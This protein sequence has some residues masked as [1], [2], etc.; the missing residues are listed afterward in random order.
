MLRACVLDFKVKWDEYL[1]LYEFAY[2]NSYHSSIGMAPFEAL[3]GR[4]CRTTVC[5]EEV[6]VHS[7]HGPAIVGE[8][9]VK[10]RLIQECLKVARSRQKSYANTRRRDVQFKEGDKVFWKVSL[11]KGVGTRWA[12]WIGLQNF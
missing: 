11:V 4:R 8:T 9:S 12:S 3:L 7:F 6:G 1:P 5:W 2:N 10:I